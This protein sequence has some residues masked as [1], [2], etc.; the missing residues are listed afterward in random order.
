[1]AARLLPVLL[2][3]RDFLRAAPLLSRHE[4][5]HRIPDRIILP[6][7]HADIDGYTQHPRPTD[8]MARQSLQ[9]T[10]RAAP[11]ARTT[12]DA[13]VAVW[14]PRSSYPARR[15]RQRPRPSGTP[16]IPG[17]AGRAESALSATS[18][19]CTSRNRSWRTQSTGT[20]RLGTTM[21][22]SVPPRCVGLTQRMPNSA[23]SPSCPG[24]G[25]DV[26]FADRPG[27]R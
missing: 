23:R 4:R 3:D 18:A 25:R 21:P 22:G 6:A 20:P 14:V 5:A 10:Q 2:P 16:Q 12:I 11:P 13:R 26:L 9:T 8:S 17:A 19:R 7:R 24:R 27:G 1:M 15:W